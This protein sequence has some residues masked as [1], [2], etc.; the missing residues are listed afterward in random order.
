MYAGFPGAP[1][2]LD[3]KARSVLG[4]WRKPADGVPHIAYP[5]R[6]VAVEGSGGGLAEG[7]QGLV[8]SIFH[9]C[10]CRDG[11]AAHNSIPHNHGGSGLGEHLDI[12]QGNHRHKIRS[13]ASNECDDVR[14]SRR[15]IG[16]GKCSAGRVTISWRKSHLRC[17]VSGRSGRSRGTLGALYRERP[18]R[19][20]YR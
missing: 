9:P 15:I 2:C 11:G 8:G 18:R 17:A 3:D 6:P 20:G 10:S 7:A 13:A 12:V 16:D 1:G 19:Y 5:Y 14:T 4:A